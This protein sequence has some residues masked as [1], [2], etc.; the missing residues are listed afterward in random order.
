MAIINDSTIVEIAAHLTNLLSFKWIF[1]YC[2]HL[3]I[4]N[5]GKEESSKLDFLTFPTHKFVLWI[6]KYNLNVYG[7]LS[8]IDA[9]KFIAPIKRL[10][11]A[12]SLNKSD[13]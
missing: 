10:S 3:G 4:I 13:I 11:K 7:S 1:S 2:R 9:L 5:F 12:H 6:G 8:E